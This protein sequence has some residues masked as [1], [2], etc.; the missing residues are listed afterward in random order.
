MSEDKKLPKS[1][2]KT[3]RLKPIVFGKYCKECKALGRTTKYT[4]N[5]RQDKKVKEVFAPSG[6]F[7]TTGVG[8]TGK[9]FFLNSLIWNLL[10]NR[11]IEYHCIV[12]FRYT[13]ITKRIEQEIVVGKERHLSIYA[14]K[15]TIPASQI[16][17][18]LYEVDTFVD[19]LILVGRILADL[20]KNPRP[21]RI[22]LFIDEAPTTKLLGGRATQGATGS[23]SSTQAGMILTIT[24]SR[25]IELM[26]FTAG[27]DETLLGRKLRSG[28]DDEEGTIRGMVH[29]LFS[30]NQEII[31]DISKGFWPE[32]KKSRKQKKK[33][34]RTFRL[35]HPIKEYVAVLPQMS[36]WEPSLLHVPSTPLSRNEEDCKVGDTTYSSK[37]I[38]G[39][40]VGK[41]PGGGNRPLNLEKLQ[42]HLRGVSEENIGQEILRYLHADEKSLKEQ[43]DELIPGDDE[44][45]DEPPEQDIQSKETTESVS[46][47]I[48]EETKS[49]VEL[50][51]TDPRE[52]KNY[53]IVFEWI[54]YWE[55]REE[56]L[57]SWE[58]MY[59]RIEKPSDMTI[60]KIFARY[61][62]LKARAVAIVVPEESKELDD[63]DFEDMDEPE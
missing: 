37:N 2:D 58:E 29:V 45:N 14:E 5:L 8:G 47:V 26:L 53:K 17:P 4:S 20:A 13:E 24:V 56:T 30:K 43:V 12:N 51:P 35:E 34:S 48:S 33:L 10:H 46:E 54:E 61:P 31:Q 27:W 16:H 15:K 57:P 60:R 41:M 1:N 49:N 39:M 62:S 19:A 52:L 44:T 32:R 55:S 11:L 9:S 3:V 6:L 63:E 38:G 21:V 18:R 22:A 28:L 40:E 23:V 50:L 25:K 42:T 7:N 59:R 36:G